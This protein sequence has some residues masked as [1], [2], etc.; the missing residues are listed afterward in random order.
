MTKKK[1]LKST[2]VLLKKT[3]CLPFTIA[4]PPTAAIGR[5]KAKLFE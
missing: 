4:V 5:F 2:I 1:Q 3:K